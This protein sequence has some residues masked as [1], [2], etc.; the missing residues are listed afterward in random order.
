[1]MKMQKKQPAD[2][3]ALEKRWQEV[4]L[5]SIIR[6]DKDQLTV[7]SIYV[8]NSNNNSIRDSTDALTKLPPES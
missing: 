5:R 3:M 8:G 2:T 1:M 7:L 6:S 4:T